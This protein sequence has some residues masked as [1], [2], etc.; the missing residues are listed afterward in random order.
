MLPTLPLAQRKPGGERK[1]PQSQMADPRRG[2]LGRLHLFFK[3]A[4]N[5]RQP[6]F[7][8]Q[9]CPLVAVSLGEAYFTSLGP[10]SSSETR[11]HKMRTPSS[12]EIIHIECCTAAGIQQ[13]LAVIVIILII[14]IT[15]SSPCA[16]PNILPISSEHWL[17]NYGQQ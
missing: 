17:S 5:I 13:R 1:D 15:R 8:V 10:V 2:Q 7:K 14:I 4:F 11:G 3:T 12:Q 9:L 6:G 16:A